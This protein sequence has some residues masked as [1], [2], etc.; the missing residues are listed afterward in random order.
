MDHIAFR[1]LPCMDRNQTA[2]NAD[3]CPEADQAVGK[4]GSVNY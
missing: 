1:I 4:A 2:Q 3:F